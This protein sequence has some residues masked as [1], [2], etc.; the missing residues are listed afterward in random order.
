MIEWVPLGWLFIAVH[1]YQFFTL[2]LLKQLWAEGE[3]SPW[4]HDSLMIC[5]VKTTHKSGS[6]G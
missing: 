5:R 6:P 3:C 2:K 4:K 1:N